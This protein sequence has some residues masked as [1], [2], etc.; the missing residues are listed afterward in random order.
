MADILNGCGTPLINVPK[1]NLTIHSPRKR[2]AWN[3]GK[4]KPITDEFGNKWCNCV[5][6][7]LTSS[8]TDDRQALC[9]LCGHYWYN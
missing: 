1:V 7:K 9:L 2:V 6:P 4:R 8:G 5:N 3:K